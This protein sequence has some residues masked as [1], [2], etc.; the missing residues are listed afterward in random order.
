MPELIGDNSFIVSVIIPIIDIVLLAFLMYRVYSIFIQ[1]R[2]IQLIQGLVFI[3]ALYAIANLLQLKTLL[4]LLNFLAPGLVIAIAIIFQPELRNMFTQL[5]Q[6]WF[7]RFR[8]RTRPLEVDAVLKA[9]QILSLQGR[10]ALMVFVR[11]VGQKN[12]IETGHSINA[13]LS[14]ALLMSIF[15]HDTPL[16][17]GAVVIE[18]GRILAAGVF[19]PLSEQQDI[20]R[21][22]GTRHR[23]ALGLAEESDAVILAVSEETGTLSLAYDAALYYDLELSELHNRLHE[24]LNLEG[25][26]NQEFEE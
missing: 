19:L 17:D 9:A 16:H 21:S 15:G 6:G 7:L 18:N 11:N 13:D 26:E 20:R 5:G 24:L 12:I 3:I 25:N 10:G 2:A 23:A 1:T 22:F 14:E 8:N 4:W